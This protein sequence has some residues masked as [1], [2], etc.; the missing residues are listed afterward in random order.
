MIIILSLKS[1]HLII[2]LKI[3]QSLNKTL[4]MRQIKYLGMS[5]EWVGDGFY[6]HQTQT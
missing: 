3:V 2:F 1:T 5:M 4:I 6:L